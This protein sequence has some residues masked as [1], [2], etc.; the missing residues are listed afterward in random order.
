MLWGNTIEE[1]IKLMHGATEDER[2]QE[3]L[4]QRLKTKEA[5]L[6]TR[7]DKEPPF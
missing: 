5:W 1:Y 4:K 3:Q 2:L 7:E 6:P